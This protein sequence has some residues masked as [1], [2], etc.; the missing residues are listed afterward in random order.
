MK[1]GGKRRENKNTQYKLEAMQA[2]ELSWLFALWRSVENLGFILLHN[3]R[4]FGP[5]FLQIK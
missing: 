4:G 2:Q 1:N 5:F 3:S